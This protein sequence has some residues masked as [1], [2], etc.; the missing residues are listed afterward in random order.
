MKIAHE[1]GHSDVHLGVNEIPRF[2]A[3]GEMQTTDWPVTDQQVFQRWL[4]EILSPQQIDAF[5][6]EKEFDGSHAFPFVRIRINLLDSL[7]GPAMV[8]RLIPQTILTMEQLKLPAVLQQMAARPKGLVLVTGPTGSGKSTTLAAMIDWINSNETRHILTIEDPV[9]F[10]HESR[11]SLIRHRE[12]GLHTL[13]FHNA[14]RAALREDPDVILVGELR[15]LET[16]RLALTAA[17]TGHVVFGTLHTSS[18]AKT[19]DRI[20]DVFP[21]EEK[22]M[23]RSMLSES[24]QGVVSQA[25]LKKNGGGR[26]AAHE[27]MVGTAAIRNLIRE[28]KVAQMYSAIQTG[29]QLGM[30]TLDQSL[31]GLLAEGLLPRDRIEEYLAA[32]HDVSL[33]EIGPDPA[34]RAIV[35]ACRTKA[36]RFV[37]TASISEHAKRCLERV[38]VDD[39]FTCIIDTRTC[40]LE[41]KHSRIAFEKAMRAADA[42]DASQCMLIDDSVKNIRTAKSLGWTTVLIGK[43]ERDTGN[44]F[45]CP[46]AD[47]HIDDVYELPSVMPHLFPSLKP[48]YPRP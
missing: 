14:L 4:G 35:E 6:R 39:L 2:R 5:F 3:R 19:I 43:H 48:P 22:S 24:L 47:Y 16:I 37:F 7:R 9:E 18:A 8:L 34:M 41:T 28:D 46:E 44:A 23:V 26:I 1:Q 29:G 45:A 36:D 32:V 21:A 12:V 25:L 13:A 20:V 15:D 17:E 11:K 40:D 31:K 30:Q 10:V 42:S 33:E 38:G 27:I